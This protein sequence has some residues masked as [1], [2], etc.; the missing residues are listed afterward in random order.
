[1]AVVGQQEP[2]VEVMSHGSKNLQTYSINRL[3]VYV[4]SEF[5]AAGKRGLPPCIG[6]DELAARFLNLSEAIIRKKIKECA[7]L[8][9]DS[10][11]KQV[12]YMKHTFN[13]PSEGDL[14]RLVSPEHVC[15]YESMLAVLYRFKHLGITQLTLPASI[16]SAMNQLPEKAIALAAASHI[17]RELLITPWNLSS[18]FVACTNQIFKEKKSSRERFVCGACGQFG[19]M[20]TNK[21]CL[22]YGADPETQL[23]IA[24]SEK[25]SGT[26][27]LLDPSSQSQLKR[28]KKKLIY[29]SATKIAVVEAPQDET[30]CTKAKVLPVKYKCGSTNNPSDKLA[31]A[32]TQSSDQLVTADVQIVNKSTSKANRILVSNKLKPGETQFESHKLSIVVQP[33]ADVD[34]RP[35]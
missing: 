1:M 12:W 14:R 25:A 4:Y 22:K 16:S 32:P 20:R 7:F 9:R 8:R 3:L 2:L 10:K 34:K 30:P 31:L 26:S 6:V 28:L 29:K 23:E 19:H 5:S 21:N 27:N 11:G 17:E 18:N 24:D 35:S 33:P 13:I 15:A